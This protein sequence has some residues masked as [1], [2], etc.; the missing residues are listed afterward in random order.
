MSIVRSI[1]GRRQFL[2]AAGMTSASALA[3]N[4]LEGVVGPVSQTGTAMAY[5]TPGAPGIKGVYSDKYS[6]LLA[7]LKIGNVIL[8]SRMMQ[9][10]SF[11]RYMM[12]PETFPS[13]Q[14]IN[15]YANIAKNGY[16]HVNAYQQRQQTFERGRRSPWRCARCSRRSGRRSRRDSRYGGES[17]RKKGSNGRR[18]H[19]CMGWGVC[20]C[21]ALYCAAD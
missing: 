20:Y 1:M 16:L 5:E 10:V 18:S 3:Y 21:P 13:E 17:G 6:H 8:K 2:V 12:G 7:P 11:P 14:V 9:A 4:K 15:H 19:A